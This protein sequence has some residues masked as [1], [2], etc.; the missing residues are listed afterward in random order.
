M[1]MMKRKMV[2]VD[3]WE[4]WDKGYYNFYVGDG[5]CKEGFYSVCIIDDCGFVEEFVDIC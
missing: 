4:D 1:V 5:D 2:V 3:Y